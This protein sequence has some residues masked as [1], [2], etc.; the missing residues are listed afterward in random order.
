MSPIDIESLSGHPLFTGL[1][2][3]EFE[4]LH[5]SGRA[6]EFRAGT[7]IYRDR[8][9]GDEL[10]IVCDGG[11]RVSKRG[12]DGKELLITILKAGAIVGEIA[13]L[14]GSLRSADVVALTHTRVLIF[15]K[16]VIDDHLQRFTGFGRNLLT[17]L[18]NRLR[19][20]NLRLADLAL[21]DVTQRVGRIILELST[22]DEQQGVYRLNDRPT[23]QD[24][25]NMAGA[26]R[27]AVTRA[28]NLLAKEGHIELNGEQILI[29]SLPSM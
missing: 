28:L 17:S 4:A 12:K 6:H 14:T 25:A 22:L 1:S 5:R 11:V 9:P 3:T 23:H 18:A 2:P 8:S 7:V 24:L 16:E 27:E 26:S 15:S 19:A 20:M 21:Y 29:Y 10:A 13:V